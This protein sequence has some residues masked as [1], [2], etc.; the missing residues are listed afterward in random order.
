MFKQL[1]LG[2]EAFG[3]P[4]EEIGTSAFKGEQTIVSAQPQRNG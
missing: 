3:R 2:E 1:E 4:G